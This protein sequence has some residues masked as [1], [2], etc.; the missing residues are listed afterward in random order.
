VGLT[1][2][3]LKR[4]IFVGHSLRGDGGVE[5]PTQGRELEL[6]TAMESES[7]SQLWESRTLE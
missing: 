7:R 5:R 2:L 1:T 3:W 6:E 4:F